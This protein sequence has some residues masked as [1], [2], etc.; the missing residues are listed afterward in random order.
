M[1]KIKI[2]KIFSR[3]CPSDLPSN[4]V[5][6]ASYPK[7]GS[8]WL[9]YMLLCYFF[10]KPW[11]FSDYNKRVQEW[12]GPRN[13]DE[14]SDLT[15]VKTH[16]PFDFSFPDT[17]II[18]LVRDPRNIVISY[19]EGLRKHGHIKLDLSLSTFVKEFVNGLDY[20]GFKSWDFNT[21][22]FEQ[23]NDKIIHIKYEKLESS[24]H[25]IL[26]DLIDFLKMKPFDQNLVNEVIEF[27]SRSSM[28]KDQ[29]EKQ[30]EI[31]LKNKALP[32]F[33]NQL[34]TSS[35]PRNWRESLNDND[36]QTLNK[37]FK[38]QIIKLGYT[39]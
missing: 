13:I 28:R 32:G 25:T 35:K 3:E 18:H 1:M 14:Y 10:P 26:K 29:I 17:P 36:A 15:L 30:E 20:D 8:T 7:S 11:T 21:A 31:D 4:A 37:K 33:E 27:C 16:I 19:Y 2:P 23:K 5:I 38:N 9:S 39:F 24:P 34:F 12:F 22:S 6:V